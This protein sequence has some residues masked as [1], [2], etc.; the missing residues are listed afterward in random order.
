MK[1]EQ[2]GQNP[3]KSPRP[4]SERDADI[5]RAYISGLSQPQIAA[6]TGYKHSNALI[7][8]LR[9]RGYDIPPNRVTQQESIEA[10]LEK[11]VTDKNVIKNTL[12]I[13][14]TQ[15]KY[16]F[17]RLRKMGVAKAV[18][19][20]G[21]RTPPAPNPD[22]KRAIARKMIKKGAS[23]R[24]IREALGFE[25]GQA[26]NGFLRDAKLPGMQLPPKESQRRKAEYPESRA[27]KI[28]NLLKEGYNTSDILIILSINKDRFFRSIQQLRAQGQ[29]DISMADNIATD[30]K[31]TRSPN[32]QEQASI[33]IKH[34]MRDLDQE[35]L[36]HLPISVER[37]LLLCSETNL[38]L[39]ELKNKYPNL[40]PKGMTAG[41][42]VS[43]ALHMAFEKASIGI[44]HKYFGKSFILSRQ[45][46]QTI[47]SRGVVHR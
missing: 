22:T 1:G 8:R 6:E 3:D 23:R 24:K 25:R 12:G 10:L 17:V 42:A 47:A 13:T 36:D 7:T 2:V 9:Q 5:V 32:T 28:R 18:S 33:T 26:F 39:E 35:T 15:L 30:K 43:A 44:Q 11:G 4:L 37:L 27:Q 20:P 41:E 19:F 29:L 16:A 14:D 40:I 38:S 31:N 34:F 45:N 46:T 21:T